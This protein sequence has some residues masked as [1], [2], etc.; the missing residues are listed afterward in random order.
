[1]ALNEFDFKRIHC[2]CLL[3]FLELLFLLPLY[4]E[5]MTV[6]SQVRSLLGLDVFEELL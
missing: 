2:C 6:L 5:V 4:N 3:V 1:M